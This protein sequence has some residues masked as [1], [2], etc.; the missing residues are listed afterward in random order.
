MPTF[1]LKLS[2]LLLAVHKFEPSVLKSAMTSDCF[3]S[4]SDAQLVLPRSLWKLLAI[5][6]TSYVPLSS[7][8]PQCPTP[9]Y[10]KTAPIPHP[11]HPKYRWEAKANRAEGHRMRL[12]LLIQGVG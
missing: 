7:T 9:L 6:C 11:V 8:I 2:L 4:G 5:R 12:N 10:P 1:R 3:S